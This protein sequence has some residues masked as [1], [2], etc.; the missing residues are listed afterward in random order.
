MSTRIDTL[1]FHAIPKCNISKRSFHSKS[2]FVEIKDENLLKLAYFIVPLS[3]QSAKTLALYRLSIPVGGV[4]TRIWNGQG[5]SSE[6]LNLTPK[7]DHSGLA[8]AFYS[9]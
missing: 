3:N 4:G 1:L 5:C 6:I 9:P 7:R 2:L 8:Q